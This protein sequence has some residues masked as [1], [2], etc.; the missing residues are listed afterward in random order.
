MNLTMLTSHGTAF[1][2]AAL[3]AVLALFYAYVYRQEARH[4]YGLG[5]FPKQLLRLLRVV[6]ALLVLVALAR[7]AL[8]LEKHEERLPVVGML[9]DES[10]SMDFPDARDNPLVQASPAGERRR[11]DTAQSVV[12]KLQEKLT[13][14]HRV[15][16]FTFSDTMKLL[17]ELAPRAK[18]SDPI[19]GRRELFQAVP[20]PTGEY[21]NIGDALQ[22]ALRE[23]SGNL[24]SGLVLLS[25]GRQTGGRGLDEAAVQAADAKVPVHSVVLG[26]EFPLRDLR[27]DDVAAAPEVSLG[28][29]L[30]FRAK[31]TNQVQPSLATRLTL[32]EQGQKVNEK[33]LVLPRGESQASIA[34][35]ANTEGTREFRL[36]LPVYDD[37]V[38]TSNNEFVVHVKVV[39][40]TLRVLLI[41][42][43]AGREYFYLVPALLRDPVVD[44]SCF[45]Q[46]SDIDYVQQ[47]KV[48]IERLPRGIEEWKKYDVVLLCDVDPNKISSQQVAEME[49]MVR[50]GGGLMVVAGRNHGLAKLI[51]VHAV[52]VRELLPI[53]IDK[54]LLPDY[55]QVFDR[56]IQAERTPKGRGHP[57]MRLE[58]DDAGNEAVWATFPPY[59]WCHPVTRVK[60]RSITL[61]EQAGANAAER[62]CLM[63]IHR[64][65]E[66]AVFYCGLDSLWQW[67]FP[68]ES[69]DYDRFWVNVIR[70]LGETRLRGTQQQVVLASDRASYAPGEEVQVRLRVLDPALMA[71]L[72]GQTLY[73]SVTSPQ[74]DVQMVPLK[75]DP[76]GEMLYLGTHRARRIG[77]MVVRARQAAPGASSEEKPLF[78]VEHPFQVR[79]QSL[80]AR[81]TSADLEAMRKLSRETGGE[82]FDYHNM[83][84]VEDLARSIP[85][86]PQVLTEQVV[87][88]VWDG[89]VLLALFL[90]L[91][92]A[93]WSLRKWWGLL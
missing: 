11:Y 5:R 19:V 39:K 87:V 86:D 28:D 20:N 71:Q 62:T 81:E 24:V 35:I 90:V 4:A 46:S 18:E 48:S 40:R 58:R 60:P 64:Y 84:S 43:S 7:P 15:Q 67:R 1:F 82:Y 29:V 53:E 79:M 85:A 27:I 21:T 65:Y 17:R 13:R 54:N 33:P 36:A 31:I 70:Y 34:T 8:M 14:T 26:T 16:V 80:E 66:G 25:D 61:L 9:V 88:E 91:I 47:G 76:G 30:S 12:Q 55:L 93:E 22:D 51:Q 32:F 3:G 73:A 59:Y 72:E 83:A 2:L 78:E 75:P 6:V 63:A 44:L 74:K 23:L 10:T 69:Y 89:S 56:A 37:E 52:K 42:G 50:T 45:L 92:C 49:N 68:Y 77:S 41:A 38:D 57:I